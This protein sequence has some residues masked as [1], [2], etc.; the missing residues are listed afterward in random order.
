MKL[1][2]LFLSMLLASGVLFTGIPAARA[3]PALPRPI[4]FTQSDGTKLT[5][6]IVGDERRHLILSAE[7]YSLAG[8]ADGD[9]YYATLSAEGKLVPTE[10]KARPVSQLTGAE[11]SVVSRLAKGLRP[12]A[13]SHLR[14]FDRTPAK[15]PAT[16][17]ATSITPPLGITD[18]KTTGQLKSLII[19]VELADRKFRSGSVRQDF[20]NLLMQDGYSDYG[21]TGSA[22]NYYQD[23]SMK[24]FDPQF[25]VVGPYTVSKKSAYYAGSEGSDYVPELVVEACRLAANNGV[26]FAEY[27]DN[28]VIRD[29]FVFYAGNN[30]AE[31][32]DK[33]SIWPHRWD[34]RGD[35]R[36]QDERLNGVLL[37]GYACSSEL[38]YLDQMCGIGTF[39]HEFGHVLGW[40]DFYDTDYIDVGVEA[41]GTENYSLMCSGSY[42]N[43]GRTPPSLNILERWMVGWASPEEITK[44]GV[45]TFDPISDNKG[46]LVR[47]PTDNDYF[48]LEYR[49]TQNKWDKHIT[50]PSTLRGMLVYHVDYTNSYQRRWYYE[51]EPNVDASHECMKLVRSVPGSTDSPAQTFFPGSKNVTTLSA[52]ANRDYQ[53]WAKEEPNVTFSNIRL[54]GGKIALTA[55]G[56]NEPEVLESFTFGIADDGSIAISMP[57]A[58]F[59]HG[60]PFQ[61]ELSDIS[62]SVSGVVW[63]IDG[64]L[65]DPTRVTLTAGEH[66][67]K[68]LVTLADDSV[69]HIVKY[70]T[71]K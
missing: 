2:T 67:V 39:C 60:V 51:G 22:W 50:S 27:A 45:M 9:L 11:K 12:T 58:G 8:G 6:R 61:M 55:I 4:V 41:P 10:V 1:Q 37:Q 42:N 65:V 19:L 21:A 14:S 33:G 30:Q 46:Y 35:Y 47:T 36:Y 59:T 52:G 40:P 24:Q 48:L 64:K 32:G 7:G 18:A 23:N 15:A 31:T 57:E 54:E 13:P 69:Q 70:I 3:V 20:H 63:R 49:D 66:T 56:Q 26:N 28:G 25:T 17:A 5:I 71:V 62:G 44:K 38:N 16:R 53:S 29:V 68:V 43:E 34:V